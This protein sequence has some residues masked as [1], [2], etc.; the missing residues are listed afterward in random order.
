MKKLNQTTKEYLKNGFGSLISNR[1]AIEAGKTFPWWA[2]LIIF[3]IFSFLPVLPLMTN[4]LKTNGSDFIRTNTYSFDREV[5]GAFLDLS[6]E[7]YTLTVDGDKLINI[8]K[9]CDVDTPIAEYIVN[10][11]DGKQ[12]YG[13]KVYYIDSVNNAFITEHVNSYLENCYYKGTLNKASI[14]GQDTYKP[15]LMVISKLGVSVQLYKFETSE[16]T[17][18]FSGD[19]LA[20]EEGTDLV[21]LAINVNISHPTSEEFRTNPTE[22]YLEGTLN[23]WKNIFDKSYSNIK[24]TSLLMSTFLYWGIYAGLVLFLGLLVFL[25]TRGKRNFNNYL[26]WYQCLCIA[27][28]ASTGPA[29]LSL[30]LGYILANF[31]VMFFI[32]FLGIRVMWLSMKQL[33]P[34]YQG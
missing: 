33:S 8:N 24:Y 9:E 12:I 15:N 27:A 4:V 26:K 31:A 2:A 6:E 23:N 34:T 17:N 29:I 32:M 13:L 18:G 14:D 25:L 20:F 16:T 5:A 19:W 1:C 22:A 30:I 10:K 11:D 21:E 7:G 28:W 3:L